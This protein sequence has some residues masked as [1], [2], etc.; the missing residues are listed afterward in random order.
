MNFEP[1]A[2][3]EI[4]LSIHIYPSALNLMGPCEYVYNN[5]YTY[6]I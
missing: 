4:L 5:A 1:K 2:E 3:P 6:A